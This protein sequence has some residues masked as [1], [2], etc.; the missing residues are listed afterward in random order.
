MHLLSAHLPGFRRFSDLRLEGVP[1]TARL[2]VL[3]GPNGTGK[4]SVFDGFRLWQQRHVG[5][6]A[7]NAYYSKAGMPDAAAPWDRIVVTFATPPATPEEIKTAF[8]IRTAYRHEAD[9]Q[10]GTISRTQPLKDL[11]RPQRMIENETTVSQDYS[12]LLGQT[13]ASLFSRENDEVRVAELRDRL[14]GT[15]RESMLHVF[16]DLVLEGIQDPLTD[17]SFF[18][19]KGTSSHW[20]YKNL[21]GGE[22]AAF[23]LILDMLIK[24]VEYTDTVYC[25]DEPETHLNV[26]VQGRV[27]TELLDLLPEAS[28][29]WIATHS[30]GMMRTAWQRAQSVGDVA[31]LDFEGHNFDEPVILRPVAPSRGLW[32][33]S[34]AVA[35][36]DLSQLVGPETVVLVEGQPARQGVR[37]NVAFDAECYRAIFSDRRPDVSF[38]SVGSSQEVL[39]DRLALGEGVKILTPGAKVW[40]LIDRDDRTES[41][42]ETLRQAGTRVLAE[43]DIESYLLS[44]EL[45]ERLAAKEGREAQAKTLKD[46]KAALLE[47]GRQKGRPADDVKAISGG[48]FVFIRRTLNLSQAGSNTE[49][50][51]RSIMAPLITPDTETYRA[52]EGCIFG[53]NPR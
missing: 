43:R 50:F 18:F 15:I 47:A 8:Y 48:L 2:V 6:A 22:R 23:D 28:Q 27:L 9:F 29:L 5:F 26:R 21:S 37:G 10:L 36:D 24:R 30:I 16:E 41:E 31:F 46:E 45:L 44:D 40:T 51:L 17:G 32:Q 53:D 20:P 33:R 38:I 11:P 13:V 42:V 49:E 34:L 35:L 1:E 39:N 19:E 3:A 4:S 14:I 25:I 52:L 12:H 7:D